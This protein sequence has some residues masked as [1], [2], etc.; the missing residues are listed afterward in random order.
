MKLR[1]H[2]VSPRAAAS[3]SCASALFCSSAA[4]ASSTANASERGVD[5]G[6]EFKDE[7]FDSL[8]LLE[9]GSGGVLGEDEGD[10]AERCI[11]WRTMSK[12]QLIGGGVQFTYLH[13]Q[14]PGR[15]RLRRLISLRHYKGATPIDAQTL[16]CC[17]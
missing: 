12:M 16:R 1:Y 4:R 3:R 13:R 14:Q 11:N 8:C 10:A 7:P 15:H 6:V 9:G 2:F 5:A 17:L